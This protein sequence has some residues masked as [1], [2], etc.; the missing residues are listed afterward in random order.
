MK[1]SPAWLLLPV[2]LAWFWPVLLGQRAASTSVDI[3]A[4]PLASYYSKALGEGRIPEWNP[5]DGEGTPTVASAE[6]GV[7]YPPHQIFYRLLDPARAWTLLLV[8]HTLAAAVFARLCA[9]GFGLNQWS[10]L[11]T[12]IVFAGQGFFVAHADRGWAAVTACWLPLA[13]HA[14]WQWLEKRSYRWLLTLAAVLGV[15]ATAGHFQVA[16]MTWGTLLLLTIGHRIAASTPRQGW[17]WQLI[18]LVAALAGGAAL[19]AA[20]LL[21]SAELAIVGDSRGRGFPFL[22]SHSTPPW[23][24]LAGH[25]MP[26]LFHANPLWEAAAWAPWQSSATETLPYVGLITV[27]L[28]I[29][30]LCAVTEDR[31]SRLWA[32]L[33]LVALLLSLGRFA[34]GFVFLTRLPGFDSFPAPGRWSL[35]AGL[36]WGLL[37]GL[38]LERL[39]SARVTNWCQR[40]S[41]GAMITIGLT[42][43]M[44]VSVMSES[45]AY[46]RS[47]DSGQRSALLQGGIASAA[48]Q[49]PTPAPA[50]DLRRILTT[51]LAGPLFVLMGLGLAGISS[52]PVR[53][54]SRLPAVAFVLV[55]V[56]LGLSA[57]LLR[58]LD[59][60]SRDYAPAVDS[61]LLQRLARDPGR[62]II[63]QL[64]R[65]PMATGLSAFSRAGLPEINRYWTRE[66]VPGTTSW[67]AWPSDWSPLPPPSRNDSLG[68]LLSR[69]PD[70]AGPDDLRLMQWSGV[71]GLLVDSLSTPPLR[72]GPLRSEGTFS[73]LSLA[74]YQPGPR[75][76]L[77][78]VASRFTLWSLPPTMPSARAWFIPL[79]ALA[80][81]GNDPALGRLPPPIRS[82][83]APGPFPVTEVV[84]HGETVEISLRCDTAG[85]VMLADQSY[86]GWTA[87]CRQN[88]GGFEPT[89]VE[90]A[91]GRWRLVRIPAR[92]DWTVRFRFESDAHRR[93]RQITLTALLLWSGLWIALLISSRDPSA[94]SR[95]T[96]S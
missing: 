60:T 47:A 39:S 14:C 48:L 54:I 76:T 31:R 36:W 96:P 16:W 65:L 91:W 63:S 23:H 80:S 52:W 28:A 75:P 71:S 49:P 38:G 44:L 41:L 94:S 40:Y 85:V 30:G 34:P 6:M 5:L 83:S 51:G 12:G 69:M 82:T 58:P 92:G 72:T 59:F 22:A 50:T 21:P 74:A 67:H 19:A 93:G 11:L 43:Y 61:P 79:A 68:V 55:A 87:K 45:E 37:A 42:T 77:V 24:L 56:D 53:H 25:L 29:L 70:R 9:R 3:H 18:G 73:D 66:Q 86:P 89:P 13:V 4:L 1:R 2:I 32:V 26:W 81:P 62:R 64:D 33:L 35:V 10:S 20:Q 8:L 57:Q 95:P 78:P 7:Y 15:Q 84:D 88:A 27:G 46:Y 90:T 17:S